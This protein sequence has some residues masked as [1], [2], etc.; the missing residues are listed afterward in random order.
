MIK[1]DNIVKE[2]PWDS[3]IAVWSRLLFIYVIGLIPT[4]I[5][6]LISYLLVEK[7]AIDARKVFKN[8]YD[9]DNKELLP[10]WFK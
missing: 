2:C 6:S 4:M 1:D 8:K 10:K 7:P 3:S 5:F 9:D